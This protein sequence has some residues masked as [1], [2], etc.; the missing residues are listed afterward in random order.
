MGAVPLFNHPLEGD[1][2]KEQ[3]IYS[4]KLLFRFRWPLL[5]FLFQL[6]LLGGSLLAV[7]QWLSIAAEQLLISS[8]ILAG[9]PIAHFLLFR[10]YAYARTLTPATTPDMLFSAWWGAGF[11][12]PQPVSS[13]RG[14]ECTVMV[15]SLF[16]SAALFVWLPLSY[17]VTLMCGTVVFAFPRLVALLLSIKQPSRCRVKYETASVAF[18]L[19]DG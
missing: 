9:I 8:S 3:T 4:Y 10:L 2:M 11:A 19:T 18:L 14:A 7:S 12:L 6:V 15:G 5:G 17:A 16:A 13:Y 1:L